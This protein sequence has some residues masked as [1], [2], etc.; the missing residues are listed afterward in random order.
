TNRLVLF[1][2]FVDKST[3]TIHILTSH[4]GVTWTHA[5]APFWVRAHKAVSPTVAPRLDGQAKMWY[6]DAGKAGCNAKATRVY[7]RTASDRTG[8]I[9]ETDWVNEGITDLSIPGYNIWHIKA[10]WVSE[11]SE[12]WM[13]ISAFPKDHDGCKTDDLFFARSNDGVHWRTYTTPVIRHADRDWTAAAVYRSTF[14]YDAATDQIN[15]WISARGSDGAW[16]LGYA[17]ARYASLLEA[18]ETNRAP[19]AAPAMAYKVKVKL[20]GEEP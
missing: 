13:L 4:D 5:R 7:M 6:V 9:V 14:L 17:R 10:R 12:Y 8:H 20:T 11:K 1:D 3:N 15:F 19:S 2:R 18:L 16:R